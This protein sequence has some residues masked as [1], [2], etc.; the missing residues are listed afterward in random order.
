MTDDKRKAR[1]PFENLHNECFF[2]VTAQAK[3][4]ESST[5]L[6]KAS[7]QNEGG[8]YAWRNC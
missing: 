8:K 6:R 1:L 5:N 7:Q 2:L 4:T 3:G